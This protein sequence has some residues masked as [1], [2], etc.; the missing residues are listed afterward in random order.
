MAESIEKLRKMTE[1][2]LIKK[3]DEVARSIVV[4]TKHYLDELARRDQER[5]AKSIR[6]YTRWITIMTFVMMIATVINVIIAL[7]R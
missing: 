6:L 5:Y 7:N 3:H 4:G 2:E 1:D